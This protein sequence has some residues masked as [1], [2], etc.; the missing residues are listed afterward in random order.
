MEVKKA[1]FHK[2]S[3][4]PAYCYNGRTDGLTYARKKEKGRWLSANKLIRSFRAYL[5]RARPDLETDRVSSLMSKPLN[6]ASQLG[7]KSMLL[8]MYVL[9]YD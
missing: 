2:G 4:K 1:I 3:E 8:L 9:V 6:N 5:R 7:L